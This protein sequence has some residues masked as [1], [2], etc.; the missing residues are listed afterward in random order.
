[1]A[2]NPIHAHW[3]GLAAPELATA[4]HAGFSPLAAAGTAPVGLRH[5]NK[6]EAPGTVEAGRGGEQAKTEKPDFAKR[7]AEGKSF[8]T[9]RARLAL[10]RHELHRTADDGGPG[11]FCVGRWGMVRELRDIN[12]VVVFAKQAGAAS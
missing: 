5:A 9:L 1:M 6:N 4:D 8:A 12:A 3:A 11:H 10:A 2:F 7:W